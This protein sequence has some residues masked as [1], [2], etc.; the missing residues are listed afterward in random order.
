[1][2]VMSK[3][4][5]LRSASWDSLW[6]M[7]GL[8]L[9]PLGALFYNSPYSETF[10]YVLL[11]ATPIIGGLHS[12]LPLIATFSSPGFAERMRPQKSRIIKMSAAVIVV[13]FAL[14]VAGGMM[15]RPEMWLILGYGYLLWNTWHFAAQNFGVLSLYRST[16]EQNSVLERKIDKFYC[17]TMGCVIM[18]IVWFCVEARWGPFLKMFPTWIPVQ[19][20]SIATVAV[21]SAMTVAYI[22]YELR[23]E[24]RSYQ[25]IAYVLSIGIQPFAA[26][27]AYYPLHFLAYSIPHWMVEIGI[28]GTI[29]TKEAQRS[30]RMLPLVN[31]GVILGLSLA[32]IYFLEMPLIEDGYVLTWWEQLANYEVPI[33]TFYSQFT[34]PALI[35]FLVVPRS[36][37]HFYISRQVFKS[38]RWTLGMLK[39][40]NKVEVFQTEKSA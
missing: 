26:V 13:S 9:V 24:N 15:N 18:P 37:F 3:S 32:L 22:V 31:M 35:S 7:S 40:E 34:I 29:Q 2:N 5:W 21:A 8:W 36:F 14:S 23:K 17:V 27:W 25:K 16:N 6:I 39:Q 4:N 30:T 10:F 1:M 11:L 33:E 38:T 19:A 20:L 28:T 12:F